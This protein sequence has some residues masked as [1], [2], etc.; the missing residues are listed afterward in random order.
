MELT[1]PSLKNIYFFGGRGRGVGRSYDLVHNVSWP[2]NQKNIKNWIVFVFLE[3]LFF[4]FS[5][6][7]EKKIPQ[8]GDNFFH[9]SK[10]SLQSLVTFWWQKIFF[11]SPKSDQTLQWKFRKIKKVVPFLGYFFLV[12]G[13]NKKKIPPSHLDL[14]VTFGTTFSLACMYFKYNQESVWS[15]PLETWLPMTSQEKKKM[16]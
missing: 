8:K 15:P 10:F 14:K 7:T 11:L 3:I 12:W 2:D 6:Q 13:E 16:V 4:L 9:F 5:P 1:V